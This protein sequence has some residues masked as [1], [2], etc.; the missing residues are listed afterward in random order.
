MTILLINYADGGFY[1]AQKLNTKSG[2]SVGGFDMA[3]QCCRQHLDP[4]FQERNRDILSNRTGAGRWLW[5]PYIVVKALREGISDGDFLFYA[6][7]GCHFINSVVPLTE[8]CRQ[9][10]KP[11]LLFTLHPSLLN[12]RYTKRDCF[13]YMGMDRAPYPDMTHILASYFLCQKTSFTSAFFEEWL[14][15]AQDPRILTEAP[16]T[17][18]LPDYPEFEEHRFDQS[19]LSLLARKHELETLPDISQWGNDFRLAEI[20]Q[21]IQH[22]RHRD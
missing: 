7:S 17:C 2:L 13:Y 10:P 1:E 4:D 15:L 19:I 5:K 11:I 3:V 14:R 21:I 22:T 6:D 9:L 20:P 16:N 12:R 8:L 18:G